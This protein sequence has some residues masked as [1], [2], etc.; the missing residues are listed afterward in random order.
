VID[1]ERHEQTSLFEENIP[2]GPPRCTGYANMNLFFDTSRLTVLK[3]SRETQNQLQRQEK[4]SACGPTPA[5]K[6]NDLSLKIL[7]TQT[8]VQALDKPAQPA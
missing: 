4:D 7:G 3:H 6:W 5:K 1:Y 2:F 8:A